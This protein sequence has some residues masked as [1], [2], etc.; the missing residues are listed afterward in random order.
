M[1]ITK[2]RALTVVATTAAVALA[3]A[4][5]AGGGEQPSGDDKY[6]K[7]TLGMTA[8]LT[9]GW[10]IIDQP[11]YQSWG[12]QAV[13]QTLC[14]ILPGGEYVPDAAESWE[15]SDD[16]RSFTAHLREGVEYSDGTPVDAASVEASFDV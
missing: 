6:A 12:I 9:G 11:A 10:D 7:L 13:Y 4:G 2:R 8:D 15:V 16:N 14:T 3:V 1:R 5:C